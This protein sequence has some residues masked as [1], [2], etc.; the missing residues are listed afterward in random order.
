MEPQEIKDLYEKYADI[1]RKNHQKAHP[2]Y[3]FAPNKNGPASR[4]RKDRDDDDDVSDWEDQEFTS[5]GR[6]TKRSR[7]ER[8]TVSR[9]HSSTPFE[10]H[11]QSYYP[12]VGP[13][14]NASSYHASNPRSMPPVY[15]SDMAGPGYYEQS[16]VPYCNGIE[17]ISVRRVHPPGTISY[18]IDNSLIRLPHN[19]QP[20]HYPQQVLYGPPHMLDPRLVQQEPYDPYAQYETVSQAP[21]PEA[22]YNYG[23]SGLPGVPQYEY[24]EPNI[25]PGMATLTTQEDWDQVIPG[26]DFDAELGKWPA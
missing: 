25:H 22:Q 11:N 4:K 3:K 21:G 6:N 17:D 2:D 5:G 23:Q 8:T 1:D 24:P 15:P 16:V 14:Q 13:Y 18:G 19:V 9:S 12:E 26:A 7:Y 10:P 20:G